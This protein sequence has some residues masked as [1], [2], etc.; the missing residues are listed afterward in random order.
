MQLEKSRH[1]SEFRV[2]G[3]AVTMTDEIIV[4]GRDFIERR[5]FVFPEQEDIAN[6]RALSYRSGYR[7]GWRRGFLIGMVV[8]C[9]AVFG[10]WLVIP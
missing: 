8:V 1:F 10:V 5:I 3:I 7:V 9:A 2:G 6:L 4:S